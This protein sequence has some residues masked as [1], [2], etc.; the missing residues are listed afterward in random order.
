MRIISQD[1][2]TDIPYKRSILIIETVNEGTFYI[3]A[4]IYDKYFWL[5]TYHSLEDAKAVLRIIV[6][7]KKAGT[8][9][10][11]MPQAN[12]DLGYAYRVM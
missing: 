1:K 12:E 5:G 4:Y 2:Q 9:C 3:H 7:N 8:N 11:E 10:Y 6:S